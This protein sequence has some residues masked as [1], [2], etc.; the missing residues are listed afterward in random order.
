M[1]FVADDLFVNF[2]DDRAKAGF[3]VLA[4]LG[5]QAQVLYLT[6]HEHLIEIARQAAGD[7]INVVRL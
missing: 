4:D 5:Q 2:D 3:H 6:H 7:N 1:P